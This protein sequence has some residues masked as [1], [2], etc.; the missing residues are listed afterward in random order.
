MTDRWPESGP[1]I[2]IIIKNHGAAIN[3][4]GNTKAKIGFRKNCFQFR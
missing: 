3:T 1:E 2:K 4:A